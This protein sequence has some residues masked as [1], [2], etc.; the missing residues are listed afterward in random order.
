MRA[1]E[2]AVVVR[3]FSV[4]VSRHARYFFVIDAEALLP[5]IYY[6][7]CEN[8]AMRVVPEELAN[9]LRFI[10]HILNFPIFYRI[11]YNL[12]NFTVIIVMRCC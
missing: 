3:A 1:R 10:V 2:R 8:C 12:H 4:V 11:S 7:P 5:A 6:R 9:V